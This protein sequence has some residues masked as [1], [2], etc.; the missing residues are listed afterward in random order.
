[1]GW[2]VTINGKIYPPQSMLSSVQLLSELVQP[3]ETHQSLCKTGQSRDLPPPWKG[4]GG[5]FAAGEWEEVTAALPRS[6]FLFPKLREPHISARQRFPK[7]TVETRLRG[8]TD[9]ASG[10]LPTALALCSCD[11]CPSTRHQKNGHG[12][13]VSFLGQAPPFWSELCHLLCCIFLCFAQPRLK[14]AQGAPFFT[15]IQLISMGF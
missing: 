15:Y 13:Q 9:Y 11:G 6:V 14:S 5:S 3:S 12:A 4:V 8:W 1:M 2:H 10:S 7:D